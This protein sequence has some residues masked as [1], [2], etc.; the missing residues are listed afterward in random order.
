MGEIPK[1]NK[2]SELKACQSPNFICD[3]THHH[4]DFKSMREVCPKVFE[5]KAV[6]EYR[7]LDEPVSGIRPEMIDRTD[8]EDVPYF[9]V[10]CGECRKGTEPNCDWVV[11]AGNA[12]DEGWRKIELEIYCKDCI[13]LIM[14]RIEEEQDETL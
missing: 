3:G 6:G 4:F 8:L 9:F 13:P 7:P 2:M 12:M 10:N 5:I 14:Q 1:E 11:A